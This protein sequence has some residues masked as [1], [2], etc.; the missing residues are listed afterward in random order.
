MWSHP[1]NLSG[2]LLGPHF[3]L[4]EPQSHPASKPKA[5]C[6]DKLPT[7]RPSEESVSHT[8]L[9]DGSDRPGGKSS[10][11]SGAWLTTPHVRVRVTGARPP[12]SLLPEAWFACSS[13]SSQATL[14]SAD[15]CPLLPASVS[16]GEV[17]LSWAPC[18]GKQRW[19]NTAL[20]LLC[21]RERPTTETH[22]CLQN[23]DW[24]CRLPPLFTYEKARHRPPIP[25][26]CLK[27]DWL[28]C[29]SPLTNLDKTSAN[30][31]S[32]T[33]FSES[34]RL[35]KLSSGTG[36]TGKAVLMESIDLRAK[37]CLIP[38]DHGLLLRPPIPGAFYL[39]DSSL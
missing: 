21:S 8:V 9:P 37:H 33:R 25:I 18:S 11:K 4:P 19:L 39:V 38:S 24:N 35:L 22:S 5:S 14:P 30:V 34:R 7:R 12:H 20:C 36:T 13:S 6:L 29:W 2:F 3:Q 1:P 27:N 26:L 28:N 17:K 16:S 32:S 31:T 15:D 10:W 23:L